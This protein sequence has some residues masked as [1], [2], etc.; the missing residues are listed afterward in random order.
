M[1]AAAAGHLPGPELREPLPL[2]RGARARGRPRPE[3]DGVRGPLAFS[4]HRRVVA[5]LRRPAD[6]SDRRSRHADGHRHPERLRRAL[7]G[8]DGLR[9]GQQAPDHGG[10]A[11]RVERPDP[12][13]HHVQGDEPVVHERPVRGLRPGAA[14]EGGR[15]GEGLQ[16]RDARRGRAGA[17]A[18]E[19]R[20]HHPWLRDGGGAGAAQG[21]RAVRP[22]EEAWDHGEVRD[23]PGGGPDAGAHERPPGR[24][25]HPLHRPRRDGRDQPRHAAGRR[26]PGGR[27]ERRRQP[28]GPDRQDEP[29]LRH[30]DH[31]RRQGPERLRHQAEQ[32]PRLRRHRQR[33]LLRTR[34]GCC[35]ATR[36]RSSAS[37]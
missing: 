19:L 5:P 7:G 14:G 32:E 11:R 33:A 22:A 17:G 15:R 24:G 31:R 3:P 20:R 16:V 13:D 27:R 4:A 6:H 30:A 36:R 25:G 12:G 23:P 18:G 37:W 1:G 28:G 29:D 10:C 9:P 8:G 2:R 26:R 21:P 35:S 34:P